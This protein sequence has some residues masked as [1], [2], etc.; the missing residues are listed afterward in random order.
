MVDQGQGKKKWKPANYT[1]KFYGPSIM[2]V[3]IE[4]SRNLM[5]ARLAMALGMEHVQDYAKRFGIDDNMPP[6]LSMSLGAGETD[7]LSLTAAY[8]VIVNG[9]HART[10]TDRPYSRPIWSNHISA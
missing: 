9:G 10:F 4:Q 8:G 5:T 2:R 3:G 6:L 7:L 1:K